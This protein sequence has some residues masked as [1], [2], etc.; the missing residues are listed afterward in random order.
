MKCLN[1][2]KPTGFETIQTG[3]GKEY[4]FNQV[5]KAKNKLEEIMYN[6]HI[7]ITSDNIDENNIDEGN[8]LYHVI[9]YESM[10]YTDFIQPKNII[11]FF[12]HIL[13]LYNTVSTEANKEV[14]TNEEF[15]KLDC[16]L[17]KNINKYFNNTQQKPYD[18]CAICNEKF[19]L[20]S[21]NIV[22]KCKHNFHKKCIKKWITEESNKCPI[23]KQPV[24]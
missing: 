22:F 13:D 11:D 10:R 1:F 7:Y 6:A 19:T 14:L 17:F 5:L 16:C 4:T 21:S 23:C 18:T 9:M 15:N 8:I 12:S 20:N 3:N 24:I 2:P